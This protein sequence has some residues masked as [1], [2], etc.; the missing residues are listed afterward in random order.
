MLLEIKCSYRNRSSK[1]GWSGATSDSSPTWNCRIDLM[2]AGSCEKVLLEVKNV[3]LCCN[4][5]VACFPD[6]V[7]ARGQKHLRDLMAAVDDGWRSVILFLVQRREA[8]LFAPADQV[9]PQY[10]RL[11]RQAHRVGVDV[12]AYRTIVN[13]QETC[14]REALKLLL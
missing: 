8:H 3:T 4:G 1:A 5:Q 14:L 11:L 12:M 10:G 7:T 9:D 2:L 13:P 6:A